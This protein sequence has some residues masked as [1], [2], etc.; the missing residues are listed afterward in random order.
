MR[1]TRL[2]LISVVLANAGLSGLVLAKQIWNF[3]LLSNILAQTPAFNFIL[4][5]IGL[6]SAYRL[7]EIAE[8]HN[9]ANECI[10]PQH[11]TEQIDALV[12]SKCWLAKTFKPDVYGLMHRSWRCH[13]GPH[14]GPTLKVT[15]NSTNPLKQI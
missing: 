12:I 9:H 14:G 15:D 5:L 1:I 11:R 3:E 7:G 10:K 4:L 8:K 2:V 13:G 6:Y